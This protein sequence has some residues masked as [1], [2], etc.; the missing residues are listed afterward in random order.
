MS[1]PFQVATEIRRHKREAYTKW[2]AYSVSAFI[3]I[4]FLGQFAR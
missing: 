4:Y 1:Y 2:F 3:L